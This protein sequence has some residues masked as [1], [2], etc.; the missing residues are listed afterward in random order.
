MPARAAWL[1]SRSHAIQDVRWRAW[2]ARKEASMTGRTRRGSRQ[3]K[4]RAR[5]GIA[6]ALLIGG[7][8]AGVAAVAANN[9][10]PASTTTES[11][12]FIMNFHHH[13]SEQAA[14]S[15]AISTWASSQQKSMNTLAQMVPMR[16]FSQVWHRH[17]MLAAQRGVVVLATKRFLLVKSANGQLHLWWLSATTK[18]KNVTANAT[19]MTAM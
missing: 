5:L 14:L 7:G 4:M 1:Q 11:A 18:F 8:A 12:G 19:G 15:S 9:H 3:A 17:T 2:R 13:I 16:S 6:T 10:G